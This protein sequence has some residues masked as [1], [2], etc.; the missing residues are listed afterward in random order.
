MNGK[1]CKETGNL[2]GSLFTWSKKNY[3]TKRHRYHTDGK[4]EKGHLLE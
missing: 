2:P 1:Q 4:N 3:V